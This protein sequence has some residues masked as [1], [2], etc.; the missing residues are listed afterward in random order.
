MHAVCCLF[1]WRYNPLW[2][3]FHRPIAGFSLLVFEVSWSQSDGPQSV[4][5]LWTGDHSVAE[6]STWQQT[7]QQTNIHAPVGFEP[8]I[9]AGRLQKTYALDR[10]ASGTGNR[11]MHSFIFENPWGWLLGAEHVGVFKTLYCFNNVMCIIYACGWLLYRWVYILFLIKVL[12]KY[13]CITSEW[14]RRKFQKLNIVC[15]EDKIMD[16]R[17]A[18]R[19]SYLKRRWKLLKLYT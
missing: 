5:L 16:R 14:R 9:S 3:Y 11:C 6:T 19:M 15:V 2:L 10:A 1:S 4:G 17:K 7:T 12:Y 13:M 18:E 8:K